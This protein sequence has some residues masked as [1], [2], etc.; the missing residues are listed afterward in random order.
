MN[1]LRSST[2]MGDYIKCGY[3]RTIFSF[4]AWEDFGYLTSIKSL[5]QVV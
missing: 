3:C 1:R 4:D 2:H 5:E